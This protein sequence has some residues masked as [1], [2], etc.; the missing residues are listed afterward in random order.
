MDRSVKPQILSCF[1]DIASA[2]GPA[3][4]PY[5]DVT[6]GVLQQAS[7]ATMQPI[8]P[9]DFDLLDHM[10]DLREGC[11]EAYTG[12][13]SALRTPTGFDAGVITPHVQHILAFIDSVSRAG[14][15]VTEENIRTAIGL[16]GFVEE[17]QIFFG[18]LLSVISL[19]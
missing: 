10:N 19:C 2:I 4:K 18:V 15:L 9:E 7:Q 12:L 3:F 11:L 17:K 13:L 16:L 1:G 6:L 8:D 5:M 14:E